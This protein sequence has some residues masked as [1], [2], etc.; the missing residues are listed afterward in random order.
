MKIFFLTHDAT[1]DMLKNLIFAVGSQNDGKIGTKLSLHGA[2]PKTKKCP[3]IM[4]PTQEGPNY[5]IYMMATLKGPKT[6]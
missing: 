1:S 6:P 3:V 4:L 5:T 2:L